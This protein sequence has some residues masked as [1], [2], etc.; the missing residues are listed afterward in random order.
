MS[1]TPGPLLE[2][3]LFEAFGAARF[4]APIGEWSLLAQ[5]GHSPEP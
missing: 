5:R 1:D 2:K 4:G 3:N